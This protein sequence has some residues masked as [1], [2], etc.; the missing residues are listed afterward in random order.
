MGAATIVEH[1]FLQRHV[2]RRMPGWSSCA[3]LLECRGSA[4]G[5]G[6]WIAISPAC[7]CPPFPCVREARQAD[8]GREG[9]CWASLWAAAAHGHDA[10]ARLILQHLSKC[11]GLRRPLPTREGLQGTWKLGQESESLETSSAWEHAWDAL[12]SWVCL[13]LS[14]QLPSFLL[15]VCVCM[16]VKLFC[17]CVLC[18]MCV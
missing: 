14:S 8:R 15:C 6:P 4:S 7:L 13:S 16:C 17:M 11:H 9:R 10:L 2:G 3:S 1:A 5:K 12:E 18:V